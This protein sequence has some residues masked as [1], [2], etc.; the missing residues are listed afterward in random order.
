[1]S[2]SLYFHHPSSLA[3][4]TGAHPEQAARIPAIEEALSARGWLGFKREE[5]PAID[6][7]RLERVHPPSYVEGIRRIAESGGGMLD[8]DTV[9]S[10][11]SFEAALHAA[12]G[13]VRAVDALLDGDAE[14]AFCGLRPPGH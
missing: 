9:A 11:G 12:G 2:R 3:H 4:D 6:L 13:A 14:V 7:G 1:M 5:A 8:L 10:D